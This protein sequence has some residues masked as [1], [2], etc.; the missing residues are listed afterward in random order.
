MSPKYQKIEVQL[1]D[2][3]GDAV[4][5]LARCRSAGRSA[6][7][8]QSVLS[9]F[10]GEATSSDYDNLIATAMRWFNCR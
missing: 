9:D 8:S 3:D 1:S 2:K 5:I 4:A 10:L 6:G 7:L